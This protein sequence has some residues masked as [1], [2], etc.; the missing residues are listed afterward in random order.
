MGFRRA[1]GANVKVAGAFEPSY[2]NSPNSGYF[3]LPVAGQV[4]L[5]DE[6]G[7]IASDL[8]GF[9]RE[10][11]EPSD[12]VINNE[13]DII[14]PVDLRYFGFWL[15]LLFGPP[16]TTQGKAAAGSI[17]F[18]DQ[19]ANNGTIT[20]NGT[21]FTFTTG[22]P[23]SGQIKVGADLAETV[24]N[25]IL[26]LNA[27]TD[28]NVKAATYSGDD[29][30]T[31]VTVIHDTI[32]TAGN[33]FTLAASTSP[34]SN[35]T[36]SGATLSGGATTG[37]YN[38]VFTSGDTDLPSASIELGMTDVGQ[39]FMNY[40]VVA[41][42]ITIPMQR[43][44]L[45]NATIGLIA[46]GER[47]PTLSTGAGTPTELV[48][49]R[50]AQALGYVKRDGVPL[51]RIQS[52]SPR[53][54]NQMEKDESIRSDGRIGGADAGQLTAGVDNLVV[55]YGDPTLFNLALAKTPLEVTVGW[56]ISPA[57][58]LS[59][60]YHRVRLPTPKKPVNGP[61]GI[62]VTYNAQAARDPTLGRT[63]TITLVNDVASYG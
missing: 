57:E 59:I 7:L 2:G 23:T 49:K 3:L 45:L 31:T 42:T 27:S 18:S 47:A 16:T 5:G 32:G 38:H 60:V 35:A 48:I 12:D 50:F 8:I 56:E 55:R 1:R 34:A 22:T 40:G 14:V 30:L 44:G 4:G 46:Q 10:P 6:Q 29:N 63:T 9:G 11:L 61:G 21:L 52:G 17:A 13:G 43:S 15:A 25:T 53:F 36:V 58:K 20:V 33:S 39:F 37:P 24:A 26:A 41:N 28:A 51:G 62:Q 54:S 19:P